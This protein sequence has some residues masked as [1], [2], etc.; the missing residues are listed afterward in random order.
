M[1]ALL[2]LCLFILASCAQHRGPASSQGNPVAQDSMALG[3]IKATAVKFVDKKNVCFDITLVMKGVDQREAMASNWSLAYVDKDSRY[4]LLSFNQRDPASVPQGGNKVSAYGTYQEWTNTFRT[5]APQ[6]KPG[7]V[8][9]LILTPK[10]LS[11]KETEGMKLEW[12]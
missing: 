10:E 7:D 11:Y 1:K 2:T 5:C 12:N 6:A 9:S 8:Q 3:N 4:H